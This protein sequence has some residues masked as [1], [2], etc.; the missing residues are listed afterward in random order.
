[1]A[2]TNL[3][4]KRLGKI[5]IAEET[6]WPDGDPRR[7]KYGPRCYLIRC[8]CG[9]EKLVPRAGITGY[10]SCG[11]SRYDHHKTLATETTRH[12]P[13]RVLAPKMRE[14]KYTDL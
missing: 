5:V 14:T 10:R 12:F 9:V 4:G 7:N 3:V 11:C 2:V 8:D 13:N 1:M 6:T